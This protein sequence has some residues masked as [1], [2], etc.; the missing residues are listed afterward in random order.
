MGFMKLDIFSSEMCN[1]LLMIFEYLILNL[2]LIHV[3]IDT[4]T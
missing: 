4:N 1:I 2:D 3:I